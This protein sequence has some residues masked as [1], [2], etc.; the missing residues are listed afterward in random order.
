MKG[1][2]LQT[3]KQIKYYYILKIIFIKIDGF[4]KEVDSLQKKNNKI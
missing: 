2:V 1:S 3:E 4:I